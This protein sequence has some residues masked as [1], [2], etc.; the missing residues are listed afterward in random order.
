[1]TR[2]FKII[3]SRGP[4]VVFDR[5]VEAASP[6]Q[7]RQLLK[8]AL[9]LESLSGVVY[10]I[11]EIPVDLLRALVGEELAKVTLP[12]R[13][14]QG[15]GK[16][17]VDVKKLIGSTVRAEIQ[18]SLAELTGRLNRLEHRGQGTAQGEVNGTR[19][20]DP[21]ENSPPSTPREEIRALPR[22][23]SAPLRAI[24][25][26]DWNAIRARYEETRSI[27][28]TAAE[29]DISPN[30]LKARVRRGGWAR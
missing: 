27:K 20:F 28:Q 24:L 29:F 3:A 1:M 23:I 19:R 21:L 14:G 30:T 22:E 25:G 8:Q 13:A 15:R 9:G 10:A 5:S 18:S 4:E 6:R 17:A 11:T 7:A 16:P 12:A 2:S 26:P